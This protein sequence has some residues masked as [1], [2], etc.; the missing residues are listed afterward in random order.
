MCVG[1]CV[2][3]VCGVVERY[4]QLRSTLQGL[5]ARLAEREQQ[6]HV[7]VDMSGCASWGLHASDQLAVLLQ[8]GECLVVKLGGVVYEKRLHVL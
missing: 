3:D 8:S 2:G 5:Q 6:T 1:M 7:D 4:A